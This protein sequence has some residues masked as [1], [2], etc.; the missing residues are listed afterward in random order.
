MPGGSCIPI[1]SPPHAAHILRFYGTVG[2]DSLHVSL[3]EY[4][5]G[6]ELFDRIVRMAEVSEAHAIEQV[7]VEAGVGSRCRYR[8]PAKAI[9]ACMPP[10]SLAQTAPLPPPPPPSP[11]PSPSNPFQS[12]PVQVSQILSAIEYIHSC[13]IVHRDLKPEV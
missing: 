5:R 6:G 7:S 9:S 13:G 11:A 2:G 3:L 4:A 12:H 8:T 1:L 10:L